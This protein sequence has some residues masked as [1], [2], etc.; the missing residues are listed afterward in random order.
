MVVYGQEPIDDQHE[1][2]LKPIHVLHTCPI[3]YLSDESFQ[4]I[5]LFQY[6][7]T[8]HTLPE[9]GPLYEQSAA[10]MHALLV[11]TH[12]F[13]RVKSY[14]LLKARLQAKKSVSTTPSIDK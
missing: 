12:E 2:I 7:H 13:E 1:E 9:D 3:S 14:E 10:T 11:C 8:F 6:T 4:L 5:E